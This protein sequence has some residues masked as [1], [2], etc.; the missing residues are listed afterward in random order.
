LKQLYPGNLFFKILGTLALLF[1]AAWVY[2]VLLDWVKLLLAAFAGMVLL[3]GWML[4]RNRKAFFAQRTVPEKLSNGDDNKITIHLESRYPFATRLQV[5]DEAPVQF[6]L[7]HL[8]FASQLPAA[9]VQTLVYHLRPTQRGEYQFANTH[10]F[11]QTRL[12]LV[13]RRF[14]FQNPETVPVYPSYIQMRQYE[15]MAISNRLHELGVKKIRRL[16]HNIEF[17]QIR[18]YVSGDDYRTINW[19]ATARKNNLMVNRYQDE[20]S[21]EVYS[22]IDKGRVMKMPFNHMSLLDYAI[23][24]ALVISNIAIKKGDK[25]GII[26]F[27]EQTGN[28]LPAGNRGR[29]MH[30]ILE[31]L[32]KENTRFL[33][34]DY[35]KL[36]VTIRRKLNRRSLILLYTNFETLAALKRQL[37]FLRRIA[38][39]HV[40][41]VVFFE[42]TELQQLLTKP[43]QTLQ[44]VYQKTI[45][46]KFDFEKKL[47][48]KELQSYGIFSI[49]TPPEHLTV[50]TI[51]KYLELKARGII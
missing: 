50:N 45:A 36:F 32:Y 46:E 43:A 26:T 34:S 28:I 47:I 14:T 10:V 37:N 42:N 11:V 15:L 40:L 24:A 12:Q 25:A 17:E 18:E 44:E 5:I 39:Q 3:D 2:P 29:Q 35:E 16:G 19:K 30:D 9:G 1:V 41:V 6:Q 27:A 31:M 51:N 33:E 38:M 21:Q 13:S 49:L 4:F 22:I 20:K 23:N 7:R 48:V 8:L